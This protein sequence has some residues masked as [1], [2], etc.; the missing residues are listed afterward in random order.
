MR[1][2]IKERPSRELIEAT[3]MLTGELGI[4]CSCCLGEGS[5]KSIFGR[6]RCGQ[7]EGIGYDYIGDNARL[8]LFGTGPVTY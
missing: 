4:I 1:N 8:A 6:R 3:L 5:N 2:H 7:C